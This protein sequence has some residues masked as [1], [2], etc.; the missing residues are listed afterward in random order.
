MD[1]RENMNQLQ[2]IVDEGVLV[3]RRDIVR[4]LRDLG[5]V[6]YQDVVDG[7]VRR[8]GEG[9][10]VEVA[11]NDHAATV[12]VNKRLYLNV[13]AFDYLKLSC[14]DTG[15]TILDLVCDR[16]SLRLLPLSD[17]LRDS[18]QAILPDAET[19][20]QRVI[21]RLLED[22]LAEAYLDELEDEED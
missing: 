16:R 5:Q 19:T 8:Q 7:S 13:Q 6:C 2:C 14:D 10:I 1:S 22:S 12:V 17:P 4:I 15:E 11:A 3:N 18:H 21:D 9:I 20:S